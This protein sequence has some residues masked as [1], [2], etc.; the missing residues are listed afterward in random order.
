M[1]EG[2]VKERVEFRKFIMSS[3]VEAQKR[4]KAEIMA[5]DYVYESLLA[6]FIQEV[7]DLCVFFFGAVG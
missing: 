6:P 3:E 1:I 7:G 4:E 5:L 2:Y